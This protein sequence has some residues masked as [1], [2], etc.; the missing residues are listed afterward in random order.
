ME[1]RGI[2]LSHFPFSP[3]ERSSF[4]GRSPALS[5]SAWRRIWRRF[6]HWGRGEEGEWW[7]KMRASTIGLRFGGKR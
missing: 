4:S 5:W 7:L 1:R 3:E 6:S 2:S